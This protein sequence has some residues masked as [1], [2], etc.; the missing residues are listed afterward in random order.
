MTRILLLSITLLFFTACGKEEPTP[1]VCTTKLIQ[2]IK[3]IDKP[4][5]FGLERISMTKQYIKS[6]YGKDV[7]NIIDHTCF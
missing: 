7:Y 3:I 1:S 5:D 2:P 6:H 4:I